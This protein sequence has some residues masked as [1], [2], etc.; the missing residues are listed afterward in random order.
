MGAQPLRMREAFNQLHAEGGISRLC[1]GVGPTLARGY[2]VNM[3]TLPMYD[4]LM[5][6][7]E[8]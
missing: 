2:L 8:E 4:A 1:K 7:F 6:R 5:N 3:I